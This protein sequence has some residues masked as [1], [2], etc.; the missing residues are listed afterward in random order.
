[1]MRCAALFLLLCGCAGTEHAP[2]GRDRIVSIDYCADQLVLGLVDRTRIAAVSREVTADP[3]F[4]ARLASGLSRIKPDAERIL[5]L[6]PTLVVRSYAGGSRLE[7]ALRRAGVRVHTLPYAESV[8]DVRRSVLA[9]GDALN[10]RVAAAA[11]IAILDR[12]LGS[13]SRPSGLTALYTTPGD[14]TAGS[15][16]LIDD[17]IRQAGL[18]NAEHR[19]GWHRLSVEQLVAAPPALI[20]RAFGEA[21]AHRTDRWSGS[22]HQALRRALAGQR[23]VHLPGSWVA[24]GNWRIGHAVTAM[25][26]AAQ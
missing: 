19:A 21:R 10:A 22:D 13:P 23:E 5:A 26:N 9:S 3:L 18:R 15:V 14:Y 11:R 1:L 25:R 20:I 17:A 4:A 7:A 24:C 6:R 16:T 12:E 2:T 8:A